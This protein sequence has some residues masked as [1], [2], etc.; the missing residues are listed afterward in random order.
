MEPA[1]VLK[2]AWA[3]VQEADLPEALQSVALREAVRLISPVATPIA[4][5][6]ANKQTNGGSKGAASSDSG[7]AS[8]S[9]D[10]NAIYDAVVKQTGVSRDKL[11]QVVHLD[12]DGLRVSLPGLKLGK[13][14][15]ERARTVAQILTITRGFGMPENETSVEV[16]RAECDRLKVY[17]SANF[18]AH[19]KALN[20]YVINGTGSNRRLRMKGPGIAAFPALID[21]LVGE[22]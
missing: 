15:A 22:G 11:E 19:I 21:G 3:A 17:D 16:I 5:P 1:D 7:D 6:P 4:T 13:N 14:N 9:L 8:P 10:E 12:D 18:S 20:G 2:K